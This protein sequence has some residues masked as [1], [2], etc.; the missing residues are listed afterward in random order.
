MDI[1]QQALVN[2]VKAHA[3]ANYEM[4]GWDYI[5]EA[6]SDEEILE[7]IGGA[8]TS[9][10]AIRAVGKTAKLLNSQRED[11]QGEIF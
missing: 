4:D 3:R 6:F 10:G 5:V 2:V 11:V 1:L 9:L 7:V 8:K